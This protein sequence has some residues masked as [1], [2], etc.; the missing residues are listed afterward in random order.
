MA[1]ANPIQVQKYLKGLDYPANKDQIIETAEEHDA[2]EA[3][4][5]AL[6]ALPDEEF[7][8]PTDVSHAIGELE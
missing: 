4:I 8:T 2:D 7:Q 1:K 5:G 3:V 6:R